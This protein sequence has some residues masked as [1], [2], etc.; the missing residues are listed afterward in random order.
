[1]GGAGRNEGG[2]ARCGDI[3]FG[4][5]A[6][7]DGNAY[8]DVS[9]VPFDGDIIHSGIKGCL[10][11]S[12]SGFNDACWFRGESGDVP[13]SYLAAKGASGRTGTRV[14]PFVRRAY[15]G[16]DSRDYPALR[17]RSFRGGALWISRPCTR[18][19]HDVFRGGARRVFR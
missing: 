1:M 11:R 18:G 9:S 5:G 7:R 10:R 6:W 17:L 15:K 2:T 12:E 4:G 13:P 8:G 3:S 19:Y 14:S 16:R